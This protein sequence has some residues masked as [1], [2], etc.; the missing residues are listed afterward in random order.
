MSISADSAVQP[1]VRDSS[2]AS[3][4]PK[5]PAEP[6]SSTKGTSTSDSGILKLNL[7]NSIQALK[8]LS[9]KSHLP[10]HS[11]LTGEPLVTAYE[12]R[13]HTLQDTLKERDQVVQMLTER[14]E[15]AADQLDRLQRTGVGR[16]SSVAVGLPTELIENQQSLME[17][18]SRVLGDWE[19]TQAG[20]TLAR[21]ESRI[22]ELRELVSSGNIVSPKL[23]ASDS[24]SK[25][26]IE[27]LV[28]PSVKLA[29]GVSV[30]SDIPAAEPAKIGWEAIKAAV[31]AG[32]NYEAMLAKPASTS[33][34]AESAT[35]ESGTDHPTADSMSW[36]DLPPAVDFA[37]ADQTTLIDAV[38]CRDEFIAILVRRL[39][40]MNTNI[41]FPDWEQ[42][43][44]VPDELH[45]EL[46]A[47]RDR[48]QEKLRVAEV[49]LSL[50]RAKLAREESRLAIKAD[51]LARQMR[52]MGLSSDE[53]GPSSGGANTPSDASNSTQGRRWLQ[54][55]QR[56]NGHG[57]APDAK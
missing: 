48:L 10:V 19:E 47:L 32:E 11:A 41:E 2:V 9:A 7:A 12:K 54:F 35:D 28:R 56:S 20:Q 8:E 25:K 38:R 5:L 36:S 16:G 15:Q 33:M 37:S 40:S 51:R 42:L 45:R 57:S 52:Q 44:F 17:Q 49:D 6:R 26:T 13:I 31:M 23:S 1:A 30:F 18:L 55:L 43:C 22:T 34:T 46:L 27:E 3:D 4:A 39:S 24:N 14:L 53:L 29:E 50:Q 21:I